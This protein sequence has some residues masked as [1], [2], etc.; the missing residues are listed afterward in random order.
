MQMHITARKMLNIAYRELKYAISRENESQI[1]YWK[2]S[3]WFWNWT[4]NRKAV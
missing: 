1:A 4:L 2:E 3:I